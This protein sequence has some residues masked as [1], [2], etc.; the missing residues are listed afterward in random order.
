MIQECV[1]DQMIH[2]Y[3]VFLRGMKE[4]FGEAGQEIC[5]EALFDYR[6]TYGMAYAF[7][8]LEDYHGVD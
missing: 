4:R 5:E 7:P 8:V 1:M 3:H 2:L 6:R